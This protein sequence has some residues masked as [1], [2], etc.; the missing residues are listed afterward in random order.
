MCT[1]KTHLDLSFQ[2]GHGG[3]T[4]EDII[5]QQVEQRHDEGGEDERQRQIFPWVFNLARHIGRG[6]P[7]RIGVIHPNQGDGETWIEDVFGFEMLGAIVLDVFGKDEAADDENDYH[8]DLQHGEDILERATE[9]QITGV[10][11]G[12]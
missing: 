10:H 2:I 6:I 11:Q 5:Q 12:D 3:G 4:Q 7:T 1:D 8:D 9:L